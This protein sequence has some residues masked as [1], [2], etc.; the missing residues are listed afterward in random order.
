VQT[1]SESDDLLIRYLRR[2]LAEAERDRVEE[3]YFADDKLHER[4]LM[5]EDQMIDSYVRGQLPPDERER[6]A[7]RAQDSR[8][9][10]RKVEFA[11]ALRRLAAREASA[12]PRHAWW[13]AIQ[14][15]LLV[16]TPASRMALAAAAVVML[17]GPFIYFQY[18]K[19]ASTP[20]WQAAVPHPQPAVKSPAPQRAVPIL[21]FVLAPI[22]R[23]G[24]EENRV[25]IPAGEYTIR[26]Q[27]D[28]EDGQIEGLSAAI[29]TAEGVRV[30]QIDGLE[31][32]TVGPGRRAVFVSLPSSR[33]HEG[34]YTVRL[35]H[36]AADGT[37]E[38]VGG[39]SFL[40]EQ[41]R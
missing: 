26:L 37:T 21:A 3:M 17:V 18:A 9:Q 8:E 5:L 28:L 4:L 34:Q 16:R 40:V 23:S 22:E 25:V 30:D 24:G 1:E 20:G 35:S 31:A 38:F 2:E 32:Q 13:E 33:L 6:L 10:R 15:F 41:R 7:R 11:E 39:Y 12:S 19:R 29:Q 27:L 36:A 14:G